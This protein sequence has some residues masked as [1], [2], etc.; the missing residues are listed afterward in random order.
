MEKNIVQYLLRDNVAVNAGPNAREFFS[1]QAEIEFNDGNLLCSIFYQVRSLYQ[2]SQERYFQIHSTLHGN[3]QSGNRQTLAER[4]YQEMSAWE[5]ENFK[6]N[7]LM[8][9]ALERIGISNKNTFAGDKPH[10]GSSNF[11]QNISDPLEGVRKIEEICQQL[12]KEWTILQLCKGPRTETTYSVFPQIHELDANI[13]VTI[14][15]HARSKKYPTPICLRFSGL[16]QKELYKKYANIANQFKQC[17]NVDPKEYITKEAKKSYWDMLFELDQHIAQALQELKN[18]F[19]PWSF[20]FS[21]QPYIKSPCEA[22]TLLTRQKNAFASVDDFCNENRWESQERVLLSLTAMNIDTL[23]ELEIHAICALL[24]TN[25][26]E[27]SNAAKL[28]LKLQNAPEENVEGDTNGNP[29]ILSLH[30]YPC[31][32]IVDERLDHFFWEELNVQQEF[33]RV[34]S[35]QCL[36]RLHSLYCEHIQSGYLLVNITDGGCLVN[37]DNNLPKTEMRMRCFFEYWLP[38]WLKKIG[39]KP[40]QDELLK[41]F[42]K[43][44]CYVYAG[45]GSGLQYINGKHI[46]RQQ[47]NCVVFLFGCESS[48]LRSNGLY[49]ELVGSHLYYHAANCPTLVGTLM[50]GLDA[51]MDGVAT[52]I[53][54]RWIAPNSRDVL[55]WQC[56]DRISWLKEG[57]VKTTKCEVPTVAN[58]PQCQIGSLCSVVARIHQRRTEQKYYNTVPYVCRGLPVWNCD[59]QPFPSK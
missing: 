44:S 59:V 55:P 8:Q 56:I 38:N 21:G 52:E 43:R 37:P 32:L 7:R 48:R 28:L 41:D 33:C 15:R 5:K 2:A 30:Y 54:S 58:S 12:P 40:T 1:D 34:N 23:S 6:S 51:N 22:A 35:L 45:H 14:L 27:Q 31:I 26:R 57:I 13:Y 42:F 46:A 11:L 50:P 16:E 9:F 29:K 4:L 18:F 20:L 49:S 36:W 3:Q 39:Q 24:T 19:F 47:M 25:S 10:N 17:I 53:L